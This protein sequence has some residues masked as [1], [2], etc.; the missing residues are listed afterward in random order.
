MTKRRRKRVENIIDSS[1]KCDTCS[2]RIPNHI[3]KPVCSLC[4]KRKHI[5]CQQLSKKDAQHI[6]QSQQSWICRDCMYS[7]LPINAV[8]GSV[9]KFKVQCSSCTGWSYS[10]NTVTVCNF[11]ENNVHKKCH[12][13]YLGCIKC[14]ESII[15]GYNVTS[16]ELNNDYNSINIARFN[17][18]DRFETIN[19]IGNQLD[20]DDESHD[21]YWN[22]ISEILTN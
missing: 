12:N 15:P 20:R 14:C 8:N 4:N 11:C 3:P 5:R 1:S 9:P 16:Y 17:P 6:I 7:I 22:E 13:E 19:S 2:V 21:H 18:Y 10:E